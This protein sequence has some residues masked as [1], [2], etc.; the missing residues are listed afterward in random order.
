MNAICASTHVLVPTILDGLS[1][2]AA[3]N[4][5][6]V[7]L[8]LREKLSPSLEI[9]GV[10][11]TFVFQKTGYSSKEKKALEYLKQEIDSRFLGKQDNKIKIFEEQR[12]LQ[13]QAIANVAGKSIAFFQDADVRNMFTQ[14]GIEVSKAFGDAFVRKLG[15]E[16][17][18][19]E[20]G[21]RRAS[22][23]VVQLGV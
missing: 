16:S 5:I 12:I 1:T 3:I 7:L 9:T 17:E 8:K 10:V 11:P 19:I 18:G 21:V 22:G 20:G 2:S 4:T 23:T 15:Y 14:L 6:D 13:K